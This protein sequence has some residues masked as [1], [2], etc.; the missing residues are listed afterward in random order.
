MLKKV[1]EEQTVEYNMQTLTKKK[2]KHS[3]LQH[4]LLSGVPEQ[5]HSYNSNGFVENPCSCRI[6][7]L[8]KINDII[9]MPMIFYRIEVKTVE[10]SGA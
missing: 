4:R 3:C 7:S 2:T 5:V 1:F 9:D 8:D 10:N 6:K